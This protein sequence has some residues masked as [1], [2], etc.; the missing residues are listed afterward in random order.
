MRVTIRLYKRH[1]L[2]LLALYCADNTKFKNDFKSTLKCYIN[3]NPIKNIIPETECSSVYAM[4]TKVGFHMILK[5]E[6]EDLKQWIKG[7]TRGRRN[8]VMKNIFR[9]SLPP[10]VSPYLAESELNPFCLKEDKP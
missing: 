2:D 9:A 6:D 4:P 7:I 10:V 8:N 1:D 3:N 5:E